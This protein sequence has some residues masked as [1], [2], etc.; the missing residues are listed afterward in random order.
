[1][2][3]DLFELQAFFTQYS[4]EL[5]AGS[6]VSALLAAVQ[7]DREEV[8]ARLDAV[9]DAIETIDSEHAR[10]LL[11]LSSSDKYLKRQ[12]ASL[13]QMLDT[14]EKT[15]KRAEELQTRQAELLLVIQTAQLKY[16]TAVGAIKETKSQLEKSLSTHL[17]GR[18]VNLM[19][20]IN[21]I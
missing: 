16:D 20:D 5:G 10:H 3:Q 1:M 7:L 14:A 2:R 15:Q 6:G 12:V 13:R 11:L 4:S 17:Q 19:G 8:Q 9:N 21:Q 18:R